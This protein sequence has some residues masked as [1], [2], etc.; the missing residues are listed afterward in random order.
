MHSAASLT[1]EQKHRAGIGGFRTQ[2]ELCHSFPNLF[3]TVLARFPTAEQKRAYFGREFGPNFHVCRSG[4]PDGS[5]HSRPDNLD[6]RMVQTA[7]VDVVVLRTQKWDHLERQVGIALDAGAQ[8]PGKVTSGKRLVRHH[9]LGFSDLFRMIQPILHETRLEIIR[10]RVQRAVIQ[11]R[12][13]VV[14]RE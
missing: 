5:M 8:R 11:R 7:P 2:S 12:D 1:V 13:F 9:E 10:N 4:V 6:D 14:G 3:A